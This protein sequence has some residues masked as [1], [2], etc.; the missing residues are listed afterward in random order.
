MFKSVNFVYSVRVDQSRSERSWNSATADVCG[1][2]LLHALHPP[3]VGGGSLH[4]LLEPASDIFRQHAGRVGV[5]VHD[6]GLEG[7][8]VSNR[9]PFCASE[10]LLAVLIETGLEDG[11]DL[12][13]E[14][15]EPGVYKCWVEGG[16]TAKQRQ[17]QS[18]VRAL[19]VL[20]EVNQ[21]INL[22]AR[23]GVIGVVSMTHAEHA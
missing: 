2:L 6:D 13:P 11:D 15:C 17:V 8:E 23:Q 18:S 5:E 22:P 10:E 4:L 16:S 3:I 1:K 19:F 7:L 20:H 14:L 21:G 9:R 12:V